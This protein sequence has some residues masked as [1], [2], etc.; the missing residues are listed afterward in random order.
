M[1]L[2]EFLKVNDTIYEVDSQAADGMTFSR[3]LSYKVRGKPL[4]W[5]PSFVLRCAGHAAAS[6][7]S[8]W[9]VFGESLKRGG[10]CLICHG[11][12]AAD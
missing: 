12:Q 6:S 1:E 3:L 11:Q 4:S 2:K 5:L 8:S 7:G 10:G 9:F